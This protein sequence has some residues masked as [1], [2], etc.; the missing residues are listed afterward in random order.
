M[1]THENVRRYGA[2]RHYAPYGCHTVKIPFA[3]VFAVHELQNLVGT[4]LHRQVD[5]LA[6]ISIFC[7][8]LQCLVTHVLRMRRREAHTHPRNSLCHHGKKLRERHFLAIVLRTIGVDVL[9]EERHFLKP[10]LLEVTAFVE[11]GLHLTAALTLHECKG[12]C[13]NGRSCCIRA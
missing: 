2:F 6:Y 8:N 5:M 4:R 1:I 7:D 11:D 12:R 13:S 10:T 9:P 3:S